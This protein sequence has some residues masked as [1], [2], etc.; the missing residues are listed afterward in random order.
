MDAK[1][2]TIFA[3]MFAEI[4]LDISAKSLLPD[5]PPSSPT[6]QP[7]SPSAASDMSEQVQ[8]PSFEHMTHL[9]PCRV[10]IPYKRG[11]HFAAHLAQLT[12]RVKLDALP[13]GIVR[14]LRRSGVKPAEPGA[15]FRI[16]R[17]LKRWGY[18]SPQ[19]RCIF[20]LLKQMGGPTPRLSYTQEA[21]LRKDF[22]VLCRRWNQLKGQLGDGR[23]NF[24]S[25]Y[26]ITQ[27]LLKKYKIPI[28]Y[29]LPSIK[30]NR[31]FNLIVEA[32]QSITDSHQAR[33]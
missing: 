32:Y 6:Y 14:R 30:D 5:T 9:Q 33:L 8:L 21:A 19:Y 22:D 27:L 29:S 26:L 24:P 16:R 28:Y 7:S 18:S 4:G 25:Y 20:A 11:T 10:R 17:L 2:A 3:E 23:K 15:Y 13:K 31:K 1:S 12:G